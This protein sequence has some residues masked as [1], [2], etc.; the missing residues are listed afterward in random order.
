MFF[1]RPDFDLETASPGTFSLRPDGGMI[2]RLARDYHNTRAMIFGDA[3]PDFEDILS[4]IREIEDRLK[5][6]R[7]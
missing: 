6:L 7:P 2:D 5:G 4:S 1:S 3:P